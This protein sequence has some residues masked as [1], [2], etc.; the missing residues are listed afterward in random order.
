MKHVSGF[1]F[2]SPLLRLFQA[3]GLFTG[4]DCDNDDSILSKE[5]SFDVPD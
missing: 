5:L 4:Y 3:L 1:S 2:L